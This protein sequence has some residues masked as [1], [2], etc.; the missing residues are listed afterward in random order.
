MMSKSQLLQIVKN[1]VAL[2]LHPPSNLSGIS[3]GLT[4]I[5]P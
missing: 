2:M 5:N 4:E 3:A 1:K